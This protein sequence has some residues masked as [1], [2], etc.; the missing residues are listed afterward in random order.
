V[1]HLADYEE[2]MINNRIWTHRARSNN[3]WLI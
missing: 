2:P 3:A 1:M